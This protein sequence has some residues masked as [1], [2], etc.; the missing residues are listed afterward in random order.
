[1]ESLFKKDASPQDCPYRFRIIHRKRPVLESLFDINKKLQLFF[2]CEHFEI[3]K[4]TYFKEHLLTAAS[5]RAA[6]K[7]H[8]LAYFIEWGAMKCVEMRWNKMSRSHYFTILK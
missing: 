4:N 6:V 7:T 1:M 3:F 2:F 8:I 5:K